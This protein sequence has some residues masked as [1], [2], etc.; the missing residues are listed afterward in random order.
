MADLLSRDADALHRALDSQGDEVELSLSR[1]T[2]EWLVLLV[3]AR[4]R[5]QE[6]VLTSSS[7][8][9]TPA[10]AAAVLGVS[11]PQVRKLM[12]AGKLEFRKVGSHHRITVE[13][14]QAFREHERARRRVAMEEL[15]QLQNEMGLLE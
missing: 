6:I 8:E 15:S 12:D 14:L 2:A 10:D 5:G 11:R 13:S 4:A 7:G 1:E 9:V 3:D